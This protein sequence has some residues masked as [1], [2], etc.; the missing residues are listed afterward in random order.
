MSE[1]IS[2]IEQLV[3]ARQARGLGSDDM[4]R[5][6]KIAPRQLES[7]EHGDWAALPGT[8]FVRG[9][10][11]AYA[12]ALE[13]DITPLLDTVGGRVQPNE[14]KPA[15]PLDEPLRSRGM[16]GFG[17]GGSGHRLVWVGL[18]LLGVLAFALFFGRGAE[19]AA[20]PSWFEKRGESSESDAASAR[21][22]AGTTGGSKVE[23][24]SL[25][26]ATT[27]TGASS[28][29][30]DSGAGSAPA[31]GLPGAQAAG[32][33]AAG[34]QSAGSQ[35]AGAQA[36]S[37]PVAGAAIAVGGMGPGGAAAASSGAGMPGAATGATPAT[38]A[39][40]AAAGGLRL[41]FAGESWVDV[42]Q[43]DGKVLLSGLQR[44]ATAQTL[45]PTGPVTLVI[46]NAAG[47]TL[48]VAGKPVDLKPHIRGSIAR[49]T[50]P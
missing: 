23:T 9:V 14:L 7:L 35:A 11:R 30:P 5:V 1:P 48:E 15:G 42:K 41:S 16:L 29:G 40:L 6:L 38:P 44:A 25:P 27:S 28:T 31:A 33:Q 37:G 36:G 43:S 34:S 2:T 22:E 4:L 49:L 13:V 47:V 21:P 18:V 26:G 39:V 45:N 46:G 20:I 3:A 10:L 12:R 19:F 8:P 24:I 32:S 50:L 17:S